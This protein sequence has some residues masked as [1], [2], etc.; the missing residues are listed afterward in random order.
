MTAALLTPSPSDVDPWAGF[1]WPDWVPDRIRVGVEHHFPAGPREWRRHTRLHNAP[2]LGAG[3]TLPTSHGVIHGR[4]VH[5]TPG[6]TGRLVHRAAPDR[7]SITTL[8][9]GRVTLV[10]P[11]R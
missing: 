6:P 4:Y 5:Y 1:T 10:G 3:L 8:V 9:A 11:P 7:T 2:E